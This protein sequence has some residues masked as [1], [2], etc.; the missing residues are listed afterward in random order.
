MSKKK[1]MNTVFIILKKMNDK[2]LKV[3]RT[4]HI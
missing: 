3:V 2:Q 4:I 1:K